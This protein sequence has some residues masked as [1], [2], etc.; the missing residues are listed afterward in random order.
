MSLLKHPLIYWLAVQKL[1][2]HHRVEKVVRQKI[3]SLEGNVINDGRMRTC[4]HHTVAMVP[5]PQE[6][7]KLCPGVDKIPFIF[8]FSVLDDTAFPGLLKQDK[9]KL[10]RYHVAFFRPIEAQ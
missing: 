10:Q 8:G 2:P 7:R 9:V 3:G 5:I 6:K 1:K 4:L